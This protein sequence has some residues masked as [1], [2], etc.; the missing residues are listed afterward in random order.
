[1]RALWNVVSFVAVVNLLAV[2]M[3]GGWLWQSG[4]LDVDR[5]RRMREMLGMTIAQERAAQAAAEAEAEARLLEAR[6]QARETNPPLPSVEQVRYVNL[7]DDQ[8]RQA[9]RRLQDETEQ[10]FARLSMN[11]AQ[12]DRERA[13]L[14]TE[15]QAWHQSIAEERQRRTDEQFQK[16]VKLYESAKPKLAK[17][18]ML[19]LI[20]K[21]E[22]HQVVAYLDAMNPRA[23]KKILDEFKTEEDARLATELLEKLRIFGLAAEA[24]EDSGDADD[25]GNF[26]KSRDG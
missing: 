4:R 21:G 26:D 8:T 20:N 1:M 18:W 9:M 25:S 22:E 16:T 23:A 24:T 19:N 10:H 7:V 13:A 3:F 2:I 15:K 5:F 12:I 11:Q 14:D 17:Q 6:E